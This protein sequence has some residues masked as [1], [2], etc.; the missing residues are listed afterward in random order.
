MDYMMFYFR[1]EN[2]FPDHFFG[3]FA[4]HLNNPQACS[5]DL[6]SYLSYPTSGVRSTAAGGVVAGDRVQ[7]R[8]W[9]N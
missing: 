5:L 4:R 8:I 3:G 1:P 2:S 7:T 6:F 9:E